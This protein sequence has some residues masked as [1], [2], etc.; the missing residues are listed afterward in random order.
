M[1]SKLASRITGVAI[2]AAATASVRAA[3]G[4]PPSPW[5]DAVILGI[6]LLVLA[7]SLAG[8]SARTLREKS[9]PDSAIPKRIVLTVVDGFVGGWGAMFLMGFSYTRPFL[10]GV[11]PPVLGAFGGLL[12]DFIRNN[13]PEWVKYLRQAVTDRFARKGDST[14]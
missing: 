9:Q 12:C 13:G 7:A 6:P 1:N 11:A 4:D 2:L 8:S 3:G 5:Y 10:E 14:P